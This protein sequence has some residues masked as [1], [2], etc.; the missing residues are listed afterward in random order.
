MNPHD[1]NPEPDREPEPEV[2]EGELVDLDQA[3]SRRSG[4]PLGTGIPTPREPGDTETPDAPSA[5]QDAEEDFDSGA[6]VLEGEIVDPSEDGGPATPRWRARDDRRPVVPAWAKSKDEARAAARWAAA[7]AGHLGAFH[8]IRTPA[9]AGKLAARAPRGLGRTV[10]TTA[11]W[12]F[13]AE[14]APVRADTVRRADSGEYMRLVRLR[15]DRVRLRAILLAAAALALTIGILVACTSGPA[16][17]SWAVL[18]ACVGLLGLAGGAADKPLVGQ[19]R[20]SSSSRPL[21]L[22]SDIVLRALGALGNA[23]INKSMAKGGTGISFPA[24]IS[25]DGPG[26]RAEIDLPYGVTVTDICARRDRLASG[27]RRP[28]GCVWPEPVAD[29]HE[30]RL[31]LWVGDTDMSKTRQPAWPLAKAGNVDLF[32]PFPFGTDQ[33]GRWVNVTLMFVSVT[34]G[35]MPRMGKTFALRQLMLAAA[36]DV[37]A[38]L[39]A[40][41]LK[42]TGDL[43]PLETVAHRYRAGDEDDDLDY[44][45][46]GMRALREELRR[47]TR[48]VRGL[49]RDVCQENK[50]TPELADRKQLRLHPIV[51]AV[52]ECQMWFEHPTHGDELEDIC[53]DLVKRGPALGIMLMLATQR[54]DADS[55]PTGISANVS[56]RFCL[57]VLGQTENDMV[58]GTSMYKNGVR[59]TQFSRA[60]KGIGYLVGEGDDAKIVRS[61][62]LDAV[63]ADKIVA[64]A[65]LAREA[66][67]TLSGYALG[68]DEAETSAGPTYSLL[69]DILTV[70]PAGEGSGK[71]WSETIADRLAELRPDVYGGWTPEQLGAALKPYG[72][73][74]GQVWGRDE[75]GAGAN[76]RG[77][78]RD[79][80]TH[81]VAER[82]RKRGA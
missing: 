62:Y 44:A 73:R 10:V 66:A 32:R 2:H 53:T 55:L 82:D 76:R 39:H 20:T 3:R 22:T 48:A 35:A 8:A 69:D 43:S 26:W 29:E 50:V 51:I 41:E 42:G 59:A 31:V 28:L 21:R 14:G 70:C 37:R 19:A 25:R 56:T 71:Y 18:A 12:V 23:E 7:Y 11:R 36:L 16:G 5:D 58:L 24:P 34:I 64:R 78:N 81:I 46:A 57:K 45:L 13:D 38:E 4:E 52:D 49:P 30:G 15:N 61:V 47:R 80:I 6:E 1:H 33:R 17:T 40:Y 65:R 74:T 68:D 54:P 9:Y 79:D 63:A 72:I 67:G 75:H 27:L 77:I 60:D